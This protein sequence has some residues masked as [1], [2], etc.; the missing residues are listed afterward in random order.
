MISNY[1]PIEKSNNTLALYRFT[2][3]ESIDNSNFN[4]LIELLKSKRAYQDGLL[5]V[6][7]EN[8]SITFGHTLKE[9]IS[10]MPEFFILF[11]KILILRN[12]F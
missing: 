10:I 6:H 12:F 9:I 5:N 1:Q 7:I 2:K 3:D 4:N 11:K 8:N